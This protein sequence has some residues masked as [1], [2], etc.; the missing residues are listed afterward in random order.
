GITGLCG[1]EASVALDGG[2]AVVAADRSSGAVHA[3][4]DGSVADT[5]TAACGG[6]ASADNDGGVVGSARRR[7]VTAPTEDGSVAVAEH[8]SCKTG[9]V[10]SGRVVV[11]ADTRN[12]QAVVAAHRG[13][14]SITAPRTRVIRISARDGRAVVALDR[15]FV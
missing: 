14:V 13:A 8:R 2:C 5:V 1:G 4:N 15:C 6:C 11:A 7:G 12:G 10:H 9:A 3:T